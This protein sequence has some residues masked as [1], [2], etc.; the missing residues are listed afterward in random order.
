M[1]GL[2]LELAGGGAA[3]EHGFGHAEG[4]QQQDGLGCGKGVLLV[5]GQGEKAAVFGRR[6]R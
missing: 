2:L 5:A 6:W 1:E 3:A 4:G